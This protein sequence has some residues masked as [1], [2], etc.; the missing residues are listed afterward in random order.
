[1]GLPIGRFIALVIGSL[2]A[3]ALV[4][5]TAPPAWGAPMTPNERYVTQA[6]DDLLGRDPAPSELSTFVMGL[7]NMTLSRSA[8]ASTL[9]TSAEFAD[10]KTTNYFATLLQRGSTAADRAG[11]DLLLEGG[12][13]FEHVEG[14]ITGTAEY[15]TSRAG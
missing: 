8:F 12:Q 2:V 5:V 15:F 11:Y 13:T 10:H 4:G 3:V 14:L 7:D 1:M 6:F 9:L